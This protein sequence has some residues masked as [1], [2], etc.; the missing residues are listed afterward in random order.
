MDKKDV[1]GN[2]IVFTNTPAPEE[3]KT[4]SFILY[5]V[6]IGIISVVLVTYYVMKKQEA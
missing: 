2:L 1:D 6:V 5:I 3:V 4:G